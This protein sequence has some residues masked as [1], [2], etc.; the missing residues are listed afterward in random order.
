MIRKSDQGNA[1]S[2]ALLLCYSEKTLQTDAHAAQE[3]NISNERS[4]DG[5]IPGL[6]VIDPDDD[7][8]DP[9]VSAAVVPQRVHSSST[10]RGGGLKNDDETRA[11]ASA[12]LIPGLDCID[13]DSESDAGPGK[14]VS[15][16][17]VQGAVQVEDINGSID[18]DQHVAAWTIGDGACGLHSV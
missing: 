9:I 13:V 1:Y 10:S 11:T 5:D 16:G 17:V 4:C 7:V 2:D 15:D 12:Q 18:G 3:E 6:N 14:F 8:G